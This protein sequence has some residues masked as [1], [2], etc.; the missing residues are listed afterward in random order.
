M[1]KENEKAN[2]RAVHGQ[3]IFNAFGLISATKVARHP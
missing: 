2:V 3:I 1:N